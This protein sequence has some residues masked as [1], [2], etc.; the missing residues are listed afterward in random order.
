MSFGT[1]LKK[2]REEKGL[3]QEQL[4]KLV[5]TSRSNITNYETGKNNASVEM[6]QKLSNVLNVSI[7]KLTDTEI[8]E[9]KVLGGLSAKYEKLSQEQKDY[10]K[11]TIEM[12]LKE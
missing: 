7:D 5:N 6:L 8:D 1:N 9:S 2:I 12:L 11:K 3:T 4:A 10:I